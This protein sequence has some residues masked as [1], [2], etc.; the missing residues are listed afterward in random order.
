MSRE[1]KKRQAS[2][3]GMRSLRSKQKQGKVISEPG[4]RSQ[5]RLTSPGV[6]QFC[7]NSWGSGAVIGR[8]FQLRAV[9]DFAP[10]PLTDGKGGDIAVMR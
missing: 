6:I 10:S 3:D 8:M 7:H 5:G 1:E 2:C 9:F 4:F